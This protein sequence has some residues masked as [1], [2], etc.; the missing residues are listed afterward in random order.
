MVELLQFLFLA[1]ALLAS[2]AGIGSDEDWVPIAWL[3]RMAAKQHL[4]AYGVG[5]ITLLGCLAVAGVLH[6]PVPRIDDEFS[7]ILTSDTLASGHVANP[8][9]PLPEFFDTLHVLVRPAYVS[10]Y[11]PAQGLFLAVGERLTGHPAVGLWLSS[12]LACAATCWMLQAWIGPAWG[13]LGGLL[14]VVQFGVYSYWSQTYWGGMVAALGGALFFGAIRRLWEH[15]SPGTAILGGIGLII[16]VNSRP[17]EGLIAVLPTCVLLLRRVWQLRQWKRVAFWLK[18]TAPAG[19]VLLAGGAATG[20]YNSAITGSAWK[21]PYLLHEQQ[22]QE[23]PQFVFLPLRPK[24]TYSS[25]WVGYYYEVMEMRRYLSQ[26]TFGNV[27]I[28]AARKLMTWWV[29][30]CGILLSAPLVLVGFLKRG[31]IRYAQVAVLSGFLITAAVYTPRSAPPRFAIDLLAFAQIVVLWFVFDHFWPRLALVTS[32]LVLFESFFTKYLFAHY[33]APAACLVLYLQV[34]ALRRIWHTQAEGVHIPSTASR[35]ERRRAARAAQAR[36]VPVLS[37]WRQMAILLPLA[38]V[39][40]LGIRIAANLNGWSTDPHGPDR[41]TLPMHDWSLQR[42]DMQRW[43]EQQSSPQL[44]FVRY[45]PNHY[46]NFEWVYNKADLIHSQVVWAR[47]LGPEHNRLLLQQFPDRTPW[48][49]EADRPEP[50]LIPYAEAP[51]P[52]NMIPP[53]STVRAEDERADQ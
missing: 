43:L 5:A 38:C 34:E 40:S 14:M 9:P 51:G 32:A 19:A 45:F 8:A 23:S 11:F 49:V 44:V 36:P 21:P 35:A 30:Y 16:L 46:V 7:Y 39:V 20:A 37:R 28:S 50:Q 13:L 48:L 29:F 4:A 41:D 25:Y 31:W 22:Y 26:R 53:F 42:A 52:S 10:K 1:L 17:V 15:L 47:D 33:F 18:V 27:M 2:L 6:E 3:R 12:A 24:I